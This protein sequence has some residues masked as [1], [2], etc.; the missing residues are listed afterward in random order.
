[1][2]PM[3]LASGVTFTVRAITNSTFGHHGEMAFPEIALVPWNTTT[4]KPQP[5]YSHAETVET[6]WE[7]LDFNGHRSSRLL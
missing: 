4:D 3:P 7:V 5:G 6:K 2:E 1:M